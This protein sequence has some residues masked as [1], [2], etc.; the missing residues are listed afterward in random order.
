MKRL[1]TLA[2]L[3][4][5]LFSPIVAFADNI[6]ENPQDLNLDA[7]RGKGEAFSM[8]SDEN[9][10]PVVARSIARPSTFKQGIS[11]ASS[12][13][14]EGIEDDEE[15]GL[16]LVWLIDPVVGGVQNYNNT[17]MGVS[18]MDEA[19]TSLYYSIANSVPD[20]GVYLDIV[21]VPMYQTMD[22]TLP[23]Y[24]FVGYR[25]LYDDGNTLNM[26]EVDSNSNL[27]G[28]FYEGGSDYTYV[29]V[30]NSSPDQNYNYT[31]GKQS[32][33]EKHSGFEVS[34]DPSNYFGVPGDIVNSETVEEYTKENLP[35]GSSEVFLEHNQTGI[36]SLRVGVAVASGESA[37]SGGGFMTAFLPFILV[38]AVLLI[39]FGGSQQVH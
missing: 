34:F 23:R 13:T 9:N 35:P 19:L 32:R 33:K 24:V 7:A 2:T 12:I 4:L 30:S 31:T 29:A 8:V 37:S 36:N 28:T 26:G 14:Y 1:L 3:F 15:E 20:S 22:D 17:V 21:T 25:G 18:T 5:W 10:R 16:S 39:A 11:A 27:V 38:G 6:L